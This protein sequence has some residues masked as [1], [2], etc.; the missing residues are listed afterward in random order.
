M[1]AENGFILTPLQTKLSSIDRKIELPAVAQFSKRFCSTLLANWDKIFLLNIVSQRGLLSFQGE[2]TD[3]VWEKRGYSSA[4]YG[5][6]SSRKD[7]TT[8]SRNS[9]QNKLCLTSI[10]FADD[11][12]LMSSF[13]CRCERQGKVGVGPFTERPLSPWSRAYSRWRGIRMNW[14]PSQ[15]NVTCDENFV[16]E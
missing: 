2:R 5:V 4:Q 8:V 11:D 15:R 16:E 14:F 9:H 10:F 1:K 6:S 13:T 7:K 3:P 12:L